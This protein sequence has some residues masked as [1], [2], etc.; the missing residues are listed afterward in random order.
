MYVNLVTYNS[1][2]I[3]QAMLSLVNYGICE[4]FLYL[5]RCFRQVY[6]LLFKLGINERKG[7]QYPCGLSDDTTKTEVPVLQQG[8][9]E[10]YLIYIHVFVTQNRIKS[11]RCTVLLSTEE[12]YINIG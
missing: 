8:Y 9:I 7:T 3:V 12:R 4:G 2:N 5:R 10:L 1:L 11:K 6:D